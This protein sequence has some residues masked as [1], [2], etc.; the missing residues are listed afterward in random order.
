MNRDSC[1]P[2]NMYPPHEMKRFVRIDS[3]N[4]KL[5][6]VLDVG[7]AVNRFESANFRLYTLELGS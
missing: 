5:L 1:G 6:F 7:I 4:V 3:T 2:W